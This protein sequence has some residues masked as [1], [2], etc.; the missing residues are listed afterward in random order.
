M[1]ELEIRFKC[2]HSC[3]R[4]VAVLVAAECMA[5]TPA[6]AVV[7]PIPAVEP[8][9]V[10]G[11]GGPFVGGGWVTSSCLAMSRQNSSCL[12]RPACISSVHRKLSPSL[13]SRTNFTGRDSWS[14][15]QHVPPPLAAT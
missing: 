14:D 11:N 7:P 13:A 1:L 12:V 8:V 9:A 15:V 2:L 6:L 5:L 3:L 4:I 10:P